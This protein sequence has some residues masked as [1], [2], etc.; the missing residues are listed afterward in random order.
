MIFV[1]CFSVIY[2]YTASFRRRRQRR[3]IHT[4][5]WNWHLYISTVR[6]VCVNRSRLGAQAAQKSTLSSYQPGVF[7]VLGPEGDSQHTRT[8]ALTPLYFL[9]FALSYVPCLLTRSE[10]SLR[11][12]SSPSLSQVLSS[13]FP[14]S[15]AHSLYF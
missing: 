1:V 5:W 15:T 7:P 3:L 11:A 4:C 12:W 14:D 8:T 13:H 6:R 10:V 9:S 2:L